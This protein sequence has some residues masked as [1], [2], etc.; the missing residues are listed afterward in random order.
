MHLLVADSAVLESR[1][2]QIMKGRWHCTERPVERGTRRR[3]IGVTLEANET[4]LRPGQ[5]AGIG[6]AVWLMAAGTA[7]QS[8][9]SMLE[10]EGTAFIAVAFKAAGFVGIDGLYR[11]G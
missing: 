9:G 10:D 11:P 5:H 3:Q 7:L 2:S 4:N 8:D 1:A 6:G